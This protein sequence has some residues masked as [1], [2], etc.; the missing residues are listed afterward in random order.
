MA[1]DRSPALLTPSRPIEP[2]ERLA[3]SEQVFL[4]ERFRCI[5]F[6]PGGFPV[7]AL[8]LQDAPALFSRCYFTVAP[9]AFCADR[10]R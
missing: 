6:R 3:A 1:V 9:S 8:F 5:G 4:V 10:Q 7:F 2:R